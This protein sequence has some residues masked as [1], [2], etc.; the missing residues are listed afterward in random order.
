[1]FCIATPYKKD[2][3]KSDEKV[4]LNKDW[5][6]L[7]KRK[8]KKVSRASTFLSFYSTDPEKIKPKLTQKKEIK[9]RFDNKKEGFYS[10]TILNI[11]GKSHFCITDLITYII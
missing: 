3:S 10:F 11:Y 1:M 7:S 4:I 2:G 9:E 6:I 5:L 8:K